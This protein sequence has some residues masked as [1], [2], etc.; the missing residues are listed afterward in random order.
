M[1][2]VVLY[3]TTVAVWGTSWIAVTFQLGNVAPVISVAYRF[4]IAAAIM[5]VL[6]L[7]TG[8]RLSFGPGQQ[9]WIALQGVLLFGTNFSL[10]YTSQFYL[11]SGLAA[12]I[13]ST[14]VFMNILASAVIFR[15]AI[16]PRVALG[17]VIGVAGIATIF[18]PE[19]SHMNAVGNTL[20]GVLFAVTGTVCAS[21]GM[22]V[23][24]RNQRAGLPVVRTNAVGMVYGAIAI[25]V[26][27]FASGETF[28]IDPRP[29]YWVA[30]LYLAVFATVIGFWSFLTLLGNIGPARASYATVMFPVVALAI[31]TFYEGFQ[32][33]LPAALG[34]ALVLAGNVVVLLPGRQPSRP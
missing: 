28:A 31:S 9:R 25:T 30:L 8:R 10:V 11:T 21:A 34:V 18:W 29:S 22:M 14:I 33:T 6:C 32:W 17:A 4:W 23:S 3:I 15:T 2:N 27:A 20:K 7:V 13:F 1:T 19:V 26:F 12:L 24:A 5:I 16:E